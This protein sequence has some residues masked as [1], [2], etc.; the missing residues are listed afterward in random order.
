MSLMACFETYVLAQ[1]RFA[2]FLCPL[3]DIGGSQWANIPT[4]HSFPVNLIETL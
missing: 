1:V 3:S 2:H 4:G